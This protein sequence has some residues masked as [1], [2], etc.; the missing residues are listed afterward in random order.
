MYHLKKHKLLK[1]WRTLIILEYNDQVKL[2]LFNFCSVQRYML[3]D[4]E[5]HRQLI[6]LIEKMLEYDPDKRITLA[7]ALE[8]E[9]FDLVPLN[10]RHEDDPILSQQKAA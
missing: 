2:K 9:F 8:H 1:A 6:D 4:E 3:S 10:Q 5:E 7:K